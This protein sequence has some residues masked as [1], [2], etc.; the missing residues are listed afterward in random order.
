VGCE[1]AN[2]SFVDL[3]CV[4]SQYLLDYIDAIWSETNSLFFCLDTARPINKLHTG[5]VRILSLKPFAYSYKIK[6]AKH[7]T[8][9]Y[10]SAEKVLGYR[11]KAS[12]ERPSFRGFYT[13]T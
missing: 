5:K 9:T 8:A 6:E 4:G 10:L 1:V 2:I 11:V 12:K 7:F 13:S 3:G